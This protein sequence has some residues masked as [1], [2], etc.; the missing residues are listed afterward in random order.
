VPAVTGTGK[1]ISE[2]ELQTQ[3]TDALHTVGYKTQHVYRLQVAGDEEKNRPAAWRTS[4]TASGW[5]DLFAI[6]PGWQLAIEVKGA[7]TPVED[8]QL[9]WLAL[10]ATLPCCRAWILRPRDDPTEWMRWIRH[11]EEAPRRHGWDQE[12]AAAAL[13]R[14]DVKAARRQLQKGRRR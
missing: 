6:R 12:Q 8:E 7:K 13:H 11:P 14:L 1:P 10:F 4:T 3:I 9:A 5:P 2:R